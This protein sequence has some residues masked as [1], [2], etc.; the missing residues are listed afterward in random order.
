MSWQTSPMLIGSYTMGRT[1][2][3]QK[4]QA[5]LHERHLGL[6]LYKQMARRARAGLSQ[7]L[8]W[9]DLIDGR[10]LLNSFLDFY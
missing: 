9:E 3:R 1:T 10:Q 6:L 2:S 4:K 7:L 5:T 8:H